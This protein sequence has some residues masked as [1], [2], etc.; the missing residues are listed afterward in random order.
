MEA[1]N[2]AYGH[3][4]F[5]PVLHHQQIFAKAVASC[6]FSS[7]SLEQQKL[8]LH[9]WVSPG[10]RQPWRLD[11]RRQDR[12]VLARPCI[13]PSIYASWDGHLD[14]S[15]IGLLESW[16]PAIKAC[17]LRQDHFTRF[18]LR[19]SKSRLQKQSYSTNSTRLRLHKTQ[20][21]PVVMGMKNSLKY[22]AY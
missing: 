16:G 11:R 12:F 20:Q 5:S 19:G 6:R 21:A 14:S 7:R 3:H 17:Y 4:L 22:C 18:S 2:L 1:L 15:H 10:G 9:A 13:N 8:R